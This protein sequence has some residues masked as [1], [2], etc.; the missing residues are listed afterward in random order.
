MKV[1]PLFLIVLLLSSCAAFENEK[2][3]LTDQATT[4]MVAFNT[5][6]KSTQYAHEFGWLTDEDFVATEPHFDQVMDVLLRVEQ[7]L[8]SDQLDAAKGELGAFKLLLKHLEVT[9]A[10]RTNL[11][12]S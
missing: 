4:E 12:P 1:L 5:I 2:A 10:T 3:R 6:V 8:K 11:D 7:L 9:Y